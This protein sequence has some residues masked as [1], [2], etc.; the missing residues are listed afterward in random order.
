MN[1]SIMKRRIINRGIFAFLLLC[2]LGVRE[3]F[4][5]AQD[6]EDKREE[7]TAELQKLQRSPYAPKFASSAGLF[8]GYDTNVNLSTTK[9]G[10]AFQQFLFSSGFTKPWVKGTR[11]TFNYDLGVINYNEITDAS[12]VLNHFRLGVHQKI[13]SFV[14]GTGYDLGVLYYPDDEDG[15]F[16]FHKGFLYVRQDISR[17]LYHQLLVEAGIKD[18]THQ[19]AMGDIITALQNKERLDRRQSAEWSVGFS[20]T[21]KLLLKFLTRFSVNDSNARYVD[22]YDYKSYEFSPRVNYRLSKK[23]E[24]FSG[25]GYLR[26]NYKTRVVTLTNY[27]EKDNTYSANAGLR[28]AGDKN[29]ILTLI[30]SYRNNSSNDPIQEYSENVISCGWQHNF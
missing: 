10:D 28:Y 6:R 5:Q 7:K 13:S 3:G 17:K 1:M 26:K 16:L 29:N 23:V 22:F 20:L 14:V 12:N 30:Y 9:K 15:D 25:F 18:Y 24:L 27:K 4:S 2:S 19:K 8:F 11:F 21:P